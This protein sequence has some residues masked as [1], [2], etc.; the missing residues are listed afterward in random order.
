MTYWIPI[1]IGPAAG[2]EEAI[3]PVQVAIMTMTRATMALMIVAAMLTIQLM[4]SGASKYT[5]TEVVNLIS[6]EKSS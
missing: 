3:T 4:I 5:T 1:A 2:L 6:N